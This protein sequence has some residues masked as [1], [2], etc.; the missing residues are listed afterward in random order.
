MP[1]QIP[2]KSDTKFLAPRVVDRVFLPNGPVQ[3]A[4][5]RMK[6]KIHFV[7]KQNTLFE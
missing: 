4:F 1:L 7:K 5:K 6:K 2:A 3:F